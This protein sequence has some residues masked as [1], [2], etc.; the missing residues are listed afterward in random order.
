MGSS[1][2][3]NKSYNRKIKKDRYLNYGFYNLTDLHRAV[4]EELSKLAKKS[5]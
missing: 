2:R 1:N 5:I 3:I 4:H